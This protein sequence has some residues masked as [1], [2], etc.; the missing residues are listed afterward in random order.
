MGSV[1]GRSMWME[2]KAFLIKPIVSLVTPGGDW[3]KATWAVG[4]L[5]FGVGDFLSNLL[6]F[7][8][9]GFVAWRISKALIRPDP[10]PTKASSKPCPYC[11]MSIDPAAVR[12]P[13]CTSQLE[14][15]AA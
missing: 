15:V 12:C 2:F 14:A 6:N 5:R 3:Q 10:E 7:F 11:R 13:H 4:P 1:P 9:I 8:I